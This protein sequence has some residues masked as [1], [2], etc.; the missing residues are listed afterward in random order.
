[1]KLQPI[2]PKIYSESATRYLAHIG[3]GKA[4]E[5]I[6]AMKSKMDIMLLGNICVFMLHA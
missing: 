6:T 3:T 2:A 5:M 1:M 4:I